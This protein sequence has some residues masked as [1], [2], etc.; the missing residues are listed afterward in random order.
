MF[1]KMCIYKFGECTVSDPSSVLTAVISA[2][3]PRNGGL[4]AFQDNSMLFFERP[5]PFRIIYIIPVC[6]SAIALQAPQCQSPQQ[7]VILCRRIWRGEQDGRS[8]FETADNG[9]NDRERHPE[10]SNGVGGRG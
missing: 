1:S 3:E 6:Y 4:Y 10:L 9:G 5:Q 7:S 2:G 8:R